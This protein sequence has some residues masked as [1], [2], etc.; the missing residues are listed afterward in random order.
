MTYTYNNANENTSITLSMWNSIVNATTFSQFLASANGVLNPYVITN[1]TT[2]MNN[3]TSFPTRFIGDK[4]IRSNYM[5]LTIN[6]VTSNTWTALSNA[7]C[8]SVTAFNPYYSNLTG[9]TGTE[10]YGRIKTGFNLSTCKIQTNANSLYLIYANLKYINPSLT[11]DNAYLR[12]R[13]DSGN[14]VA[15][16]QS[17]KSSPT[18][19]ITQGITEYN[20]IQY[21]TGCNFNNTTKYSS[22]SYGL[23]LYVTTGGGKPLPIIEFGYVE[24]IS[25]KSPCGG[26]SS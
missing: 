15:A 8:S 11:V 19:S 4:D 26:A 16:I 10:Q 23:E 17:D 21:F 6:S 9:D 1:K 24:L 22:V 3:I 13:V 2:T 12:I 7:N 14:V 5:T 25:A 20:Q 18:T